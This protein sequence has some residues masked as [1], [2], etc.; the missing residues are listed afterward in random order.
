MGHGGYA[1]GIRKN[2]EMV[3]GLSS[4]MYFVDLEKEE[5][6]ADLKAK[7]RELLEGFAEDT[8]V[9]FACDLLGASPFRAAAEICIDHPGKYYAAAGLNVMALLEMD[10]DEGSECTMEAYVNRAIETTKTTVAK[11]PE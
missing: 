10:L 11:F 7:V 3:A 9:L 2:I 1:E 4:H 5:D 8:D 6:L